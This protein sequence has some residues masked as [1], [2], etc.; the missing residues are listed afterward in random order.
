[1]SMTEYLEEGVRYL[2]DA[3][4]GR[5]ENNCRRSLAVGNVE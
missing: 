3:S 2:N 4:S 5:Q 1:M